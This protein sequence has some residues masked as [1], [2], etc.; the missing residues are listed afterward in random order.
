M[1]EVKLLTIVL[2]MEVMFVVSNTL[3]KAAT[4]KRMSNYV[5][6]AYTHAI[7]ALFLIPAAFLYHR[8]TPPPPIGCST[9][10]RIFL[11]AILNFG[12]SIFFYTGLRY[13]SPTLA[14]AMINLSLG[15]TFI[16]AI[17]FRLGL[18]GTTLRKC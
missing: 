6:I 9:I 11:L 7:A 17:I 4:A 5:Y 3:N 10:L 14:S 12:V 13:S 1:W 16:I 18:Q 8:K 2:A 15:F